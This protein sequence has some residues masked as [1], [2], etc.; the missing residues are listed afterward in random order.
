M[1]IFGV[2]MLLFGYQV[3]KIAFFVIWFLIGYSLMQYFMPTLNEWVPQI[4]GEQLWQ[5]LLPIAGGL[6]L[7]LLGL[8]IEKVCVAGIVFG[9]TMVVTMKYF[10]NGIPTLAT[11]AIIGVILGALAV[12]MMKPA[13]IIA[14]SLAGAYCLTVALL[15]WQP[16]IDYQI[17]YFPILVGLTAV[18]AIFQFSTAKHL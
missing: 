1:A 15:T 16:S 2:V 4:A 8:S 3:K 17:F 9:L 13:I 6:L 11:G 7:A 10:G 5:I 18:G 14:T 12:T